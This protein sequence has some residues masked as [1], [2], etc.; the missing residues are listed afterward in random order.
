MQASTIN[1]ITMLPIMGLNIVA[2]TSPN[3]AVE[4]T[5]SALPTMPAITLVDTM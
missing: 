5:S 3:G 1:A 4:E 2:N